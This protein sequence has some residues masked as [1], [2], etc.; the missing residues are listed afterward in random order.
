[1]FARESCVW[2]QR[3]GAAC[4]STSTHNAFSKISNKTHAVSAFQQPTS[5][6]PD[7]TSAVGL[8]LEVLAADLHAVFADTAQSML[9]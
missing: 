3:D 6:A 1:M 7:C 9:V 4:L 5:P 8:A 2:K